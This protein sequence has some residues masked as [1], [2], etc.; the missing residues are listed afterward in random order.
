MH[1]YAKCMNE[2]IGILF[3]RV[4]LLLHKNF[5]IL[6]IIRG[7]CISNAILVRIGQI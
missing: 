7:G 3:A 1:F 2:R 5:R 4:F 6:K